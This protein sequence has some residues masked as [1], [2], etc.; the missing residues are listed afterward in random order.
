MLGLPLKGWI[1]AGQEVKQ[2][3]HT[4]IALAFLF[5]AK[6]AL[7]SIGAQSM[8]YAL[9]LAVILFQRRTEDRH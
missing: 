1:P 4:P 5:F 9:E 2:S 8:E 7:A 3:T 6:G